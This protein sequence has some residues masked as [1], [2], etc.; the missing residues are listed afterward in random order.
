[1]ADIKKVLNFFLAEEVL[2]RSAEI[3][4]PALRPEL[5]EGFGLGGI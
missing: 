1:M 2:A 4:V 5:T 3:K